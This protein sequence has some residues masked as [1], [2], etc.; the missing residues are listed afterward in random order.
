MITLR[1]FQDEL[2]GIVLDLL[3]AHDLF[4]GYT[5]ESSIAVVQSWRDHS[6]NKLFCGTVREERTDR[7]DTPECEKRSAA[8]ATDV[9]FHWQRLVKVRN[10]SLKRNCNF[11]L[12]LQTSSRPNWHALM[13][14]QASSQFFSVLSFS[15]LL[16]IHDK[17]SLIQDWML[18]WAE[19]KLLGG[20]QSEISVSSAYLWWSQLW[21]AMTSDRGCEYRV[22]NTGPRADPWGTPKTRGIGVDIKPSTTTDC[23]LS[24]RYDSNQDSA[25]PEI[26][27]VL[28][29][30]LN[31]IPEQN[32]LQLF[33]SCTGGVLEWLLINF[34]HTHTT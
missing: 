1:F 7:G 30:R 2:H 16:C 17:V 15:L 9:L 12:C 34:G 5:R 27:K 32:E 13:N 28:S 3:Y 31:R 8:E 18:D 29:S 25:N 33:F 6:C 24:L 4:I 21:H 19:V 23:V 22:N 14:L 10:G 26:P 11:H 20:A